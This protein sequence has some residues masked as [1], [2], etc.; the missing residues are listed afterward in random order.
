[1]SEGYQIGFS[2]KKVPFL[3][4]P[5]ILFS[6]SLKVEFLMLAFRASQIFPPF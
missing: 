2:E 6:G 1:V 5:A 3:S 4:K